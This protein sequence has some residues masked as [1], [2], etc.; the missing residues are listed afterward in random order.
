M[1]SIPI[2]YVFAEQDDLAHRGTIFHLLSE[3]EI[4]GLRC[5]M[6]LAMLPTDTRSLDGRQPEFMAAIQRYL[7]PPQFRKVRCF[8]KPDEQ[9][10]IEMLKVPLLVVLVS[11]C[12][13]TWLSE[14]AAI[15]P[16]GVLTSSEEIAAELSHSNFS[17]GLLKGFQDYSQAYRV[18]KEL[19]VTL[20]ENKHHLRDAELEYVKELA[21]RDLFNERPR[22][23]FLSALPLPAPHEGR[24]AAYLLNRLSNNVDQPSLR[25]DSTPEGV[26]NYPF[27][28]YLSIQACRALTFIEQGEQ[29]PEDS[30]DSRSH[31]VAAY[32]FLRS[33][34]PMERK[35]ERWFELGRHLS[36]GAPLKSGLLLAIPGSRTDLI[37][38][39]PPSSFNMDPSHKEGIRSKLLALKDHLEGVSRTQFRDK[40]DE[41]YYESAKATLAAGHRLLAVQSAFLSA[42]A[43]LLPIQVP[44]IGSH[45]RNLVADFNASLV[46]GSQKIS[47]VFRNLEVKLSESLPPRILAELAAGHSDIT[48]YSDL[49][50]EWTLVDNFPICLSR[51]VSRMPMGKS[52][53]STAS[54]MLERG[55]SINIDH[56]ERVLVLDLVPEHD[57]IRRYSEIF[58]G[59]AHDL[60]HR[61][62]YSKP[63]TAHELKKV[64]ET[65]KPEMVIL[66]S[67]G[68]YDKS[69]DRL[70]IN[71]CGS[72]VW[73]DDFLPEAIVPPIWILS[74]CDMAVV[75]S[76]RGTM[77]GQLLYRGAMVVI[78]TLNEV[79]AFAA[80]MFTGRLLA[81]IYSPPAQASYENL[82][83][84]FFASQLT[85]ALLYDP[86]F[87]LLRRAEG[88]SSL[89]EP[90]GRM[91]GG[92]LSDVQGK[93]LD[94]KSFKYEAAFI[95]AKHLQEQGLD[96][97]Q[98]QTVQSGGV[99]PQSLLFTAFGFPSKV[100]LIR[101][102][103]E[104]PKDA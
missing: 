70:A 33:N 69:S 38:K 7:R 72:M 92:Y 79:D 100:S 26:Y 21:S 83:Y 55:V 30:H 82:G 56:P 85:T 49:P 52:N 89:R 101:D 19:L 75:G 6:T 2:T 102:K 5:L 73:V 48:F 34:E 84:A 42:S 41:H 91:I 64:L 87:P 81:D 3:A 53:W 25:A 36:E 1:I 77:V 90:L 40:K 8:A 60:G 44:E 99:T 98:A 16:C 10:W 61:F 37:K 78:A 4:A 50:F 68:H 29:L 45:L 12:M 18:L 31:I 66:D 97:L 35:R 39:E 15:R 13:P 59:V 32:D 9:I 46:A 11:K 88:D 86:L 57:H 23:A 20:V 93:P 94:P 96:T 24:T 65:E 76:T 28:L 54:H 95:L 74:A 67:H 58:Q 103:D 62:I 22:L 80:T 104:K 51:P 43:G 17:V 71:A 14:L 27:M 63:K 47:G